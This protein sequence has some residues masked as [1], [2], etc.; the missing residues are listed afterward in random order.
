VA[1][2]ARDELRA[3]GVTAV[4]VVPEGAEVIAVL[5]WTSRVTGTPGEQVADVWLFRLSPG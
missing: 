3:L 1:A 4:V 2:A 5:D